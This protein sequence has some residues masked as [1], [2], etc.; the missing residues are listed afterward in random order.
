[1][2]EQPDLPVLDVQ[3]EKGKRAGYTTEEG[4]V[5]TGDSDDGDIDEDSEDIGPEEVEVS[6]ISGAP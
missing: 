2:P 5:G 3:A 1:M 6:K 4:A